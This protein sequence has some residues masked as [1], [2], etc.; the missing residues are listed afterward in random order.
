MLFLKKYKKLL[1]I[2]SIVIASLVLLILVAQFIIGNILQNRLE[3]S[4]SS[5]EK[6]DYKISVGNV[7]VNLFTMTLILKD[8]QIEPDSLLISQIKLQK[9]SQKKG[10]RINIPNLRV[11]YIGVISFIADKYV[12][13]GSFVIKNAKIDLLTSGKSTIPKAK[14]VD[15]PATPFNIDSIV[16]PGIN[17]AI[18][19]RF[20]VKDF[21]FNIIDI[22]HND[23]IF[24]TKS[25]N[26]QIKN[27]A[28][29]KN[30]DDSSSF[31]LMLK[32]FDFHMSDE[33]F[34]LPGDK[35]ILSFDDMSFNM[36]QNQLIF[37]KLKITPRYSQSSMVELS[38]FQYEI[39]N[40]EIEKAEFNSLYPLNIIRSSKIFM[41]D[42]LIHNMKLSIF[43]DKRRPFDT[44]KRPKL[45]QQLLKSLK[46]DLYIDSLIINDSELIYAERHDM[47]EEPMVVTLGKLNVK[48]KDITSIFDSIVKGTV[49]SIRLQAKLQKKIPMGVN[50]YFPM[51][52]IA[53]T[54]S[55]NGWLGNGDMELFNNVTL[56]A[57]GVKF[58]SGYLDGLSFKA[59]ANPT[60]SMGEM[61]MLYHDLNGIVVRKDMKKT[62]KFL[63]WAANQ[64]INKN[65]PAKNKENRVESMFFNRVMYKGLGNFLWKTLQSGILGTIIPGMDN[66]PKKEIKTV[67]GTDKKDI[68]KRKREEKKKRQ[69]NL[70]K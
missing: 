7:K 8:V 59:R 42:V 23:T 40:C 3:D 52:S 4:L 65:N 27:I 13:V 63:S 26:V 21:A 39:Y 61:T 70:S 2:T 12:D 64:I 6:K 19:N 46:Q 67:L 18:L 49:M 44:K 1:V 29:I 5:S 66:K 38:E 33:R 35:Y 53:D 24:Q 16:L 60:Y 55:F 20:L 17:G 32:D 51:R 50:I 36:N 9:W 48:V 37:K 45:P 58:K 10:F 68:R 57:I 34:Q 25:F 30:E 11:R 14:K 62:N 15:K 56:P 22:K 43:K 31:R 69:N 28:L 54:F 47:M 41:S